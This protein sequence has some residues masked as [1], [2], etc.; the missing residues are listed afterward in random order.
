MSQKGSEKFMMNTAI[1]KE[2]TEI[3]HSDE[4]GENKLLKIE[5]LVGLAEKLVQPAPQS[6]APTPSIPSTLPT[7]Q[8]TRGQEKGGPI[9]SVESY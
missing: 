8:V 9:V 7:P 3:I 4:S 1:I 5:V 6:V 2:I